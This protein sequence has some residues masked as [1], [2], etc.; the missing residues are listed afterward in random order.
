M[1]F[2]DIAAALAGLGLAM[3][4][5]PATTSGQQAGGRP[6]TPAHPR[7]VATLVGCVEREAD[8]RARV[9]E[10][11]GGALGTGIGV[12]NEYV[13]TDVRTPEGVATNAEVGTSGIAAVYSVTGRLEKELKPSVGRMVQVLGFVE[14]PGAAGTHVPD[15][16]RIDVN[17]WRAINE[18]CPGR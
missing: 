3:A 1:R 4:L 7:T 18:P 15:L 11:K 12:D 2:H 5:H 8:Y 10:G 14:N 13:L 17:A 9:N 16:P 6:A